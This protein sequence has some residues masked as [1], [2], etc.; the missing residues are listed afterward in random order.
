MKVEKYFLLYQIAAEQQGLFTAKQ[1]KRVGF[2]ERNHHY[3]V[4]RG[5][6]E[7]EHRGIYRLRHFPEEPSSE[8]TLWSLWSCDRN[9]E[10][11]GVYSHETALCIYDLTDLNPSKLTMTVLPSFRR[12]AAIPDILIL[13]K[14]K[15]SPDDWQAVDGYR[16]TTP[17]RTLRDVMLSDHIADEFIHQAV[18]EAIASGLCPKHKLKKHGILAL[19]ESYR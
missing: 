16:V 19:A 7:K 2:D 10:P 5:D 17:V 11:Q 13:R 9:G 15:L 4:T 6:W 12:S 8:Y 1:A 14:G 3:Y 18:R